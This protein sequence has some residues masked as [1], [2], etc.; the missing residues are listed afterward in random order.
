MQ[1]PTLTTTCVLNLLS[2]S[3]W[4]DLR[5]TLNRNVVVAWFH[6]GADKYLIQELQ[7][8]VLFY[9]L[10]IPGCVTARNV[11]LEL[12]R[13][14]PTM[15]LECMFRAYDLGC[16]SSDTTRK[17]ISDVYIK[18]GLH[19]VSQHYLLCRDDILNP[20][21]WAATSEQ[22]Q[23]LMEENPEWVETCLSVRFTEVML[24]DI[25]FGYYRIQGIES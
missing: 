9:T 15:F 20:R 10:E 5:E 2:P 11:K 17:D 8:G 21:Y 23:M 4:A 13:Y 12:M 18:Y 25:E 14:H 3:Q 6:A 16:F 19:Q 24:D 7:S 1:A 22:I